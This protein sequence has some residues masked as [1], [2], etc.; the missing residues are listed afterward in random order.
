VWGYN[1]SIVTKESAQTELH[2][3]KVNRPVT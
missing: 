3:F 1:L 2:Y